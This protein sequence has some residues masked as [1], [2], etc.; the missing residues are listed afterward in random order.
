MLCKN[1]NAESKLE[2]V[3]KVV[4]PILKKDYLI[5]II[6]DIDNSLKLNM[7][8]EDYEW[9]LQQIEEQGCSKKKLF[10]MIF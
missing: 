2:S 10:Y 3:L 5:S 8:K 6:Q 9:L 1:V 4:I 7:T